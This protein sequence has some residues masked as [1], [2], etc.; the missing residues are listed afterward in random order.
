MYMSPPAPSPFTTVQIVYQTSKKVVLEVKFGNI[1]A[2]L[3]DVYTTKVTLI[4]V[5]S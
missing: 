1:A 2:V 5:G 4:M 3:I